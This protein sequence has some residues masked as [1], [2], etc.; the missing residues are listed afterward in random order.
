MFKYAR[1]N[2]APLPAD[3]ARSAHMPGPRELRRERVSLVRVRDSLTMS[4]QSDLEVRHATS[5]RIADIDKRL[6]EYGVSIHGPTKPV[7]NE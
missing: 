7:V 6:T 4:R 1:G 2:T 3:S 5:L